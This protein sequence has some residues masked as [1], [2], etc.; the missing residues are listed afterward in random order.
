MAISSRLLFSTWLLASSTIGLVTAQEANVV[1]TPWA[2]NDETNPSRPPPPTWAPFEQQQIWGPP[3]SPPP[4]G[5][6]VVPA[7]FPPGSPW[8]TQPDPPTWAPFEQ[9]QIDSLQQPTWPLQQDQTDLPTAFPSTDAS[10]STSDTSAADTTGVCNDNIRYRYAWRDLTCEEQNTYLQAVN[11]LKASGLYD[12][13]VRT[14]RWMNDDAH[15][16]A[17]TCHLC[18]GGCFVPS[19]LGCF[20]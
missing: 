11:R 3:P 18:R 14:H 10:P 9:Q 5:S 6:P 4:T 16:V 13:F 12:D 17:G 1:N 7:T 20:V 8:D 2:D 15:G 19:F